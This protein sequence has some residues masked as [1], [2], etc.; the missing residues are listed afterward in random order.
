MDL[1]RYDSTDITAF[2]A[3]V[4][5]YLVRHEAAHSLPLGII[6]TLRVDMARF[7]DQPPYLATVEDSGEVV[8]VAMRT[9]PYNLILSLVEPESAALG[10]LALV[11]GD[12]HALY[13]TLP[14]VVGPVPWSQIFAGEWQRQT[15]QPFTPGM[16]E[17]AYALDTVVPVTGVHGHMRPATPAD[18]E[19]LAR[20]VRAFDEEA[21]GG[22]DSALRDPARWAEM[23]L[24]AR[25]RGIYL[26]EDGRGE[27]VS[28]VGHGGPT[29]HGLR[30]GP[31]YTPPEHRSHGYASA[32]TAAVS[33]LLL[34]GGRRFV[35]LFTDLA[36]PTSNKIYQQIGYRP[37]CDVDVYTFQ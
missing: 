30:I 9:P 27:V 15:G 21:L 24:G 32:L 17:R 19:L 16:K 7:G 20:W 33:Q 31:V 5:P 37:V 11:A 6:S 26:W 10:A 28:L 18:R 36:N 4:E 22:S 13:G 34:D 35:F 23:M 12:A 25:D 2:A 8:A 29:P 14:G 3:Q 1:K